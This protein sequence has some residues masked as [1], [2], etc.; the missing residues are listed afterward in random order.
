MGA[1]LTSTLAA[2]LVGRGW[3]WP[4]I[5][6]GQLLLGRPSRQAPV[7]GPPQHCLNPLHIWDLVLPPEEGLAPNWASEGSGR[8]EVRALSLAHL[9][10]GVTGR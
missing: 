10:S 9:D 7:Q 5:G 4:G 2:V 3:G 6:P 1:Q 8:K